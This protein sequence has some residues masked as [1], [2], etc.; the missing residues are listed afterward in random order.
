M[1]ETWI[2]VR[3]ISVILIVGGGV[4][5]GLSWTWG[6]YGGLHWVF[7]SI[8]LVLL[9][10][11]FLVGVQAR[12]MRYRELSQYVSPQPVTIVHQYPNGAQAYQVGAQPYQQPY[13]NYQGPQ[14]YTQPYPQGYTQGY[15]QNY[16]PGPY[17]V[18]EPGVVKQ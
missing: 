8:G 7:F 11:G 15:P 10:S 16:P 6:V 1:A 9:F 2:V 18:A 12:R 14:G 4:C 3:I 13:P 17:P 5:F